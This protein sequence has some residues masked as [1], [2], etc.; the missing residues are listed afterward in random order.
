MTLLDAMGMILSIFTMPFFFALLGG[1]AIIAAIATIVT[2]FE[3]SLDGLETA[4][5]VVGGVIAAFLGV[6]LLIW[7]LSSASPFEWVPWDG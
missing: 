3:S 4:I 1:V 6:A 2:A 7:A 5:G